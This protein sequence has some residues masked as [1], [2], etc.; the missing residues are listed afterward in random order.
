MVRSPLARPGRPRLFESLFKNITGA[1]KSGFEGTIRPLRVGWT[2]R[3]DRY[4]WERSYDLEI[5]YLPVRE[6]DGMERGTTIRL[7]EMVENSPEIA[8]YIDIIKDDCWASADGDDI[9]FD[10]SDT[11][12]DGTKIDTQVYK[13]LRR[14]IDEVI[15]GGRLELAPERM[16]AWGDAFVEISINTR[17]RQIE[18]ILFLPTWQMFRIENNIGQLMGFEQRESL[19]DELAIPFHPLRICHFRFRRKYLYGRGLFLECL[20]YWDCLKNLPCDIIKAARAIGI[21]PNIHELPC[22]YDARQV[23]IYREAVEQHRKNLGPITDYYILQGASIKKL[24]S[25]APDIS[26]LLSAANFNIN[27]IALKSRIPPWQ[28]GLPTLG[29]REISGA[30]ER[31]YA[32]FVNRVRQNTSEGLRHLCNLELALNGI[33]RERWHYRLIWP[34]FYITSYED[35]TQIE[36]AESKRKSIEDLDSNQFSDRSIN[37]FLESIR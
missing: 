9:G 22:E 4:V 24:S 36:L 11:L 1:I 28:I 2:S 21:N 7:I 32:R 13:I 3:D 5:P 37:E 18:N 20:D 17:K 6:V 31:G 15:G 30:P 16:L 26:A 25:S 10:V 35:K 34:Q 12:S 8:N 14:L 27:Q 33:P 19:H 23:E 29:A